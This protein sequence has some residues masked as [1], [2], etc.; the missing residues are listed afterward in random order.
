MEAAAQGTR[1]ASRGL[2]WAAAFA[3][4]ALILYPAAMTLPVLELHKLGH[5]RGV[6]VWSGA[7]DLISEGEVAVGLLVFVCSIVVPVLKMIGVLSLSWRRR[8]E[9]P[10][11]RA[12]LHR[13]IEWMGRWSMLDV[14]L[15]AIL[16]AAIKL[17]NWAEIHAGPG[18]LAYAA[19]VVMSLMASA[20]FDVRQLEADA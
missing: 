17:G 16:V 3:L 8:W 19:L 13:V 12:R 5:V 14:L 1:P 4:G 11:A 7:V 6:T 10:E 9:S 15:V 18:A 2:S 20:T